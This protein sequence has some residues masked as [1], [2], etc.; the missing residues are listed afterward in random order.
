MP[1]TQRLELQRGD[2][3]ERP[4]IGRRIVEERQHRRAHA[5][6]LHRIAGDREPAFG[7]VESDRTGRMARR[8]DDA[9][10]NAAEVDL[11]AVGEDARYPARLDALADEDLTRGDL[12]VPSERAHRHDVVGI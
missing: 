1:E 10:T 9:K 4:G 7:D 11:V 3:V 5:K 12:V 6:A 8:R 2:P